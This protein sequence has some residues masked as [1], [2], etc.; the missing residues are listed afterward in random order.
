[1]KIDMPCRCHARV[2]MARHAKRRGITVTRATP[3]LLLSS[4]TLCAGPKTRN[5]PPRSSEANPPF[6]PQNATQIDS[7]QSAILI[8]F[9]LVSS[10]Y[11]TSAKSNI[12]D[13][14]LYRAHAKSGAT[15]KYVVT[16]IQKS[17]RS[18]RTN[19]VSI[20]G[21]FLS[22]EKSQPRKVQIA[23][24]IATGMDRGNP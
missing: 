22:F 19:V 11:I 17:S 7:T 5:P 20:G 4:M 14:S 23:T 8:R 15:P 13:T 2:H 12:F 24:S 21:S 10:A 6:A 1:M 3:R 18:T 16:V 9:G